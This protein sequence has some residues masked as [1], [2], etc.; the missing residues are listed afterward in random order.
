MIHY[1]PIEIL[2]KEVCDVHHNINELC[3]KAV[4]DP[5]FVQVC[6]PKGLIWAWWKKVSLNDENIVRVGKCFQNSNT[7]KKTL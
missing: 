1:N 6:L 3:H 2:P 5:I 4:Q 7:K